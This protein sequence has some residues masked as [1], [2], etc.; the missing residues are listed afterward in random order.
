MSCQQ[1][2]AESASLSGVGLHTGAN[3]NLKVRPTAAGSGIFFKRSDLSSN[4]LIEAKYFNVQNT[5]F[6][7]EIVNEFGVNVM[8]IEHL[9]AAI[10]GLGIDNILVEVNGPEVP[11]MD[12]S[13]KCFMN[14]LHKCGLAQQSQQRKSIKIVDKV[15]VS[16]GEKHI[17]IEQDDK[18]SVDF[19]IDFQHSCIGKQEI[20]YNEVE[21]FAENISEART[22]GFV[23]EMQYLK[24]K[25]LAKGASLNNAIGLDKTRVLNPGGLR[26]KDEFVKH[27]VL[28]CIGDLY[29]AGHRIIGKVVACKAGHAMNNKLLREVFAKPESYKIV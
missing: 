3:V 15:S 13:S 22:F 4:N 7:T 21:D 6:C 5:S 28:D 12:G 14:L 18:F 27:K 10:W 2:I 24:T 16:D 17:A 11:A 29:L 25:G 19:S 23:D 8:T 20:V 9:M 1:T 26:S